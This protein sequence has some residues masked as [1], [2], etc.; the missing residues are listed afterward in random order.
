MIAGQGTADQAPA[1]TLAARE[2]RAFQHLVD[3]LIE[4]SVDYLARQLEA[5]ADVVQIFDTWAG[6]L[7]PDEFERW[8]VQPAKRMV[9]KLRA[10]KPGAKVIGFP[11]GAG[12]N[13]PRYVEETGV[14]AVSLGNEIDREFARDQIQTRVP[15]QGNVDPLALLEGGRCARTRSGRR[16]ADAR[17]RPADLQSRPW[18]PAGDADRACRAM[19]KRVRG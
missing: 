1:K 15:V 18:H 14:T 11:R 4:A 17:R 2:P 3:C 7:P 10:K 6:S 8:C 16:L 5:G 13:I 19:L 12:K 9:A